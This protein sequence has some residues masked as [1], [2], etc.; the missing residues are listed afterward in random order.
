MPKISTNHALHYLTFL[1][2]AFFF[3]FCVATLLIGLYNIAHRDTF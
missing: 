1:I 3:F 2:A